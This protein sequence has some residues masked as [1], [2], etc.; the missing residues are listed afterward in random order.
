M[1]GREGGEGGGR[2]SL[3]GSRGCGLG[4]ERPGTG[5]TG[6]FLISALDGEGCC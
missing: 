5:G 6:Y 4:S 1:K 3:R 2:E